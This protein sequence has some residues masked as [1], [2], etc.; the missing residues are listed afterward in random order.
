LLN[1]KKERKTNT[2]DAKLYYVIIGLVE[3]E[4]GKQGQ[5][6]LDN[7]VVILKSASIW[8]AFIPEVCIVPGILHYSGYKSDLFRYRF[9]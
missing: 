4:D 5:K 2:I 8:E 1:E 3:K 9:G 6:P 7:D